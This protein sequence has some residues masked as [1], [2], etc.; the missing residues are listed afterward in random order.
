MAF[1]NG[2]RVEIQISFG[3]FKNSSDFG[4]P[5]GSAPH[6]WTLN[7]D[8]DDAALAHGTTIV[9]LSGPSC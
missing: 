6:Y 7:L 8:S 1:G 4:A 3:T 5:M 9:I 2:I